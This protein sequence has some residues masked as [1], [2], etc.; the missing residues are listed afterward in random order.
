MEAGR[1]WSADQFE[2]AYR[3]HASLARNIAFRIV[4]N[5]SDADDV[6]QTVFLRVWQSPESF[7]GGNF[8]SW[9]TVLARNAAIDVIRRRVR[10]RRRHES[11][12][13]TLEAADVEALALRRL[14]IKWLWSAVSALPCEQRDAVRAAF[15]GG[16]SHQRI[17][18][19]SCLPVGTVKSRIRAGIIRLR[20]R[21]E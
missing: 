12:A 17:A 3:L 20:R 8:E 15:Y 19:V 5:G 10:D 9:I 14:R 21:M 2:R 13:R 4:N 16:A 11:L 6:V 1:S 18:R 7:Q